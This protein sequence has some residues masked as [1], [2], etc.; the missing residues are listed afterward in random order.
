M[1]DFTGAQ[2]LVK[3]YMY[4][5]EGVVIRPTEYARKMGIARQTVYHQL[6]SL[7]AMGVPITKVNTGQ[8][9]LLQFVDNGEAI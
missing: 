9:T 7:S 3:L 4:L 2:R 5:S 1:K 6:E 8:W